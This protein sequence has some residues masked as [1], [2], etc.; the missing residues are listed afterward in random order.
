V[1]A[2]ARSCHTVVPIPIPSLSGTEGE[3]QTYDARSKRSGVPLST[4]YHREHGRRSNEE[5]AQGQQYLT[6]SEEKALEKF[7]KLM[8]DFENPVRIKFLPSFAF[9]IARQRSTTNKSIKPPGKN[10]AQGFQ[11]RHLAL[12]SR[13]VRAIDWKRHEKNIYDKI[14]HWFEVIGKVLQD[15]AIQLDPR[16]RVTA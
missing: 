8:S 2:S 12:K 14:I 3:P 9:S 4:L 15:P 7:L 1:S 11:K 16:S 13:R 5:K 6:P 10:W